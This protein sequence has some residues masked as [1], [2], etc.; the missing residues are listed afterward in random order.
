M[1]FATKGW[2]RYR[3]LPMFCAEVWNGQ[4]YL[5]TADGRVCIN[6]GYVDN[7]RRTDA[8]QWSAVEYSVLGAWRS[9][10]RFARVHMV[11]AIVRAET[12][13]VDIR[14]TAKYNFNFTEPNPPSG[15][16]ST[17][18]GGS[19][20]DVALWDLGVW[21]GDYTTTQEIQGTSGLGK[22]VAIAIRG[23]ATARTVYLGADIMFDEGGLL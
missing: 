2:S 11:R 21:G 9:N 14:A 20:W 17:A 5:G 4:L 1:S 3:D 18:L 7:V 23:R 8:T 12:P 6:D 16:V 19:A 13:V 10:Q 22:D 15:A